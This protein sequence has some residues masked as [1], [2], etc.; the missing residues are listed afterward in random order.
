MFHFILPDSG[1]VEMMSDELVPGDVVEV[2]HDTVMECDAV[3]LNGSV[4]I[5]ESMLTGWD[6]KPVNNSR[7]FP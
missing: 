7:H 6:M 3:L 1:Y 4:I 5:N 2:M